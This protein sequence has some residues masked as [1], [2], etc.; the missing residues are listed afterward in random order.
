MRNGTPAAPEAGLGILLIHGIGQQKRGETLLEFGEPICRW[1]DAVSAGGVKIGETFIAADLNDPSAPAHSRARIGETTLLMAESCWAESFPTPTFGEVAKWALLALPWTLATQFASR[2]EPAMGDEGAVL[3]N[4]PRFALDTVTYVLAYLLGACVQLCVAVLLLLALLPIPKLRDLLLRL[5]MEI[6]G[7]I[8][9]SYVFLDSPIRSG[10][11]L[12]KARRDLQ[13]L[14]DRC[15]RV[16]IVAH[17]QGAAVA[18][19]LI[20]RLEKEKIQPLLDKIDVYFSFGSGLRKL[21]DLQQAF[22]AGGLRLLSGFL[23]MV[24]VLIVTAAV[25]LILRTTGRPNPLVGFVVLLAG[26]AF[27]AILIFLAVKA[28]DDRDSLLLES[29]RPAREGESPKIRWV[30]RFATADPV[31]SGPLTAGRAGVIDSRPVRNRGAFWSDHTTYWQNRDEFLPMLVSHLRIPVEFGRRR[32][33][34]RVAVE[35]RRWRVG[36]LSFFRFLGVA[37]LI[38][39]VWGLRPVLPSIAARMIGALKWLLPDSIRSASLSPRLSEAIGAL[40]LTVLALLWFRLV[41]LA[42]TRWELRDFRRTSEGRKLDYGG[43]PFLTFCAMGLV[44]PALVAVL[45][46]LRFDLLRAQQVLEVFWKA[47][48]SIGFGFMLIPLFSAMAAAITW[49]VLMRADEKS[50]GLNDSL[51]GEAFVIAWI[52]NA[53]AVIPI[54]IWI[55]MRFPDY[56]KPLSVLASMKEQTRQ[57]IGVF[58]PYIVVG[59]LVALFSRTLGPPL[60]R[61]LTEMSDRE[62]DDSPKGVPR[63]VLAMGVISCACA[64]ASILVRVLSTRLPTG[65]WELLVLVPLWFVAMLA[66]ANTFARDLRSSSKD[67]SLGGSLGGFG[68]ALAAISLMY[69]LY[70]V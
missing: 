42:W 7:I 45:A 1:L 36:W 56:L 5:Q 58:L 35:R 54:F 68:I 53:V 2:F 14:A 30:D 28:F 29:F 9:D 27:C 24:S 37:S 12:S 16:A 67:R 31:S 10:A 43:L 55:G 65:G 4:Y 41:F 6:A 23:V 17:S 51:H 33:P 38:G 70:Q 11:I 59:G 21:H 69:G 52:V 60:D 25:P 61:W 13:W 57:G 40:G 8:G 32:R 66:G 39:A 19:R 49:M 46:A 47:R 62:E 15:E 18:H 64:A 48:S 50:R 20:E 22:A 34:L 3:R 26:Y 44:V 63:S